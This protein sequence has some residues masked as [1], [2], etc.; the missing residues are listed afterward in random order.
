MTLYFAYGLNMDRAGMRQ[1]CPGA[2]ALGPAV[3]ERHRFFI[4][5]AGWGSVRTAPG[6][7]VHGVLWRLTP[8]DLA[9]L[10]AYELLHKG[11]YEVRHVPVR[12]GAR[13]VSALIYQLRRRQDGR[14]RPGYVEACVAAARS[15]ALPER[16]VR[17]LQRWSPSRGARARAIDVREAS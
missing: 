1:R 5:L 10:N 11:V 15:W 7:R 16:Y 12:V 9:V 6:A 17:S 8:R 4:G 14:A 13:R 3:L 2:I